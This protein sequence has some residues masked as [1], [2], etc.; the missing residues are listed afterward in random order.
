MRLLLINYEYPPLGGGAGNAT[1]HL[2]REFAKLGAEVWV[3]TSAFQELPRC[4]QS[5]GFTIQRVPVVRRYADRCTPPEM[6]TFMASATVASLRLARKWRPDV[7]IAFFGIPSG[8]AAYAL[9][10]VY[11][12]PY[13]VSLRGGDVP[14]F[15]PYDLAVYHRLMGPVIRFLWR[16]AAHVVANSQGLCALAQ[17]SAP[18]VAVEV[19]PNGVDIERFRPVESRLRND[20]VRLLFV[21]R[22]TYQKGADTLIRAL[23]EL[24]GKVPFEAEL[25]GDGDARPQLERMAEQFDLRNRVHFFG[26]LSRDEIPTRYRGADIFVLP[27]RDEGMPNVV[28]E[29]MASG[30]PV[31]A[32]DIAGS[33]ELVQHGETGL[34][35]PPEDPEGLAGALVEL[36]G[37]TGLR[38]RM[39]CAGRALVEQG[40]AWNRVAQQYLELLRSVVEEGD[41]CAASVVR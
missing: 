4:E 1:A 24:D 25:V 37:T 39:G 28:L 3:L 29:A 13:V 34:L 8:P 21:G 15:Q 27:S 35:V 32:S 41:V 19:I 33:E 30:L 31:I 22:L 17:R 16:K 5:A 6:L 38:E 20:P 10:A 40:Y 12:V 11:G 18:D 23:H 36:V 9:K 7:T 14:G 26:W 2:A